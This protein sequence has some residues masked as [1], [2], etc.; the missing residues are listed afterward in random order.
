M[1]DPLISLIGQFPVNMVCAFLSV[2]VCKLKKGLH[3][4]SNKLYLLEQNKRVF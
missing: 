1:L 3:L 4:Y 2:A